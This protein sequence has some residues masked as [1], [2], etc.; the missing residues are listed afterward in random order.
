MDEEAGFHW[1]AVG[2]TYG[3]TDRS[4]KVCRCDSRTITQDKNTDLRGRRRSRG[5]KEE[6]QKTERQTL[7]EYR[8]LTGP[9]KEEQGL[10]LLGDSVGALWE[11][12]RGCT[13]V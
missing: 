9:A 5:K 6:R 4:D 10:G 1:E 2:S 8:L 7:E 13:C 11:R 3:L 12:A